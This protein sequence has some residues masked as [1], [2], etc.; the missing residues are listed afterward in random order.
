MHL[1]VDKNFILSQAKCNER[2]H[3][4][5][6]LHQIIINDYEINSLDNNYNNI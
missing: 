2:W 4:P 1:Y 6:L 3:I 5:K